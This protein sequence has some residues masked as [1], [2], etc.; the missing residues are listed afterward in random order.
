MTTVWEYWHS[1]WTRSRSLVQQRLVGPPPRSLSVLSQF[2]LL[3]L[4]RVAGRHRLGRLRLDQPV[5][6]NYGDNVYYQDDQVY[7][8]DQPVATAEQYAQQAAAIA[9]NVPAAKPAADDWMPLGVFAITTTA[10]RPAPSRRCICSWPSA[11]KA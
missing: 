1:H 11:S 7:Y 5:Y 3:G 8:G 6:Y 9:A 2:Q 4:G 10:S